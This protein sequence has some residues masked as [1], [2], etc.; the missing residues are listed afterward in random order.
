MYIC[1]YVFCTCCVCMCMRV[2]MFVSV[3]VCILYSG[4]LLELIGTW[5]QLYVNTI[6]LNPIQT[7]QRPSLATITI[8][9]RRW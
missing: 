1:M 6:I 7:L 2:C 3:R 4:V 8:C 9:V 5:E